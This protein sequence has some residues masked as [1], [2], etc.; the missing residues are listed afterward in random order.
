M[1]H[2]ASFLTV[3]RRVGSGDDL[4][5]RLGDGPAGLDLDRE[6][7]RRLHEHGG[8]LVNGEWISQDLSP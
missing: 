7:A 1:R 4:L 8:H 2:D 5:G 6:S 3:E